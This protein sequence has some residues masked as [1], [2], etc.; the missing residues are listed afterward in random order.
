[1]DYSKFEKMLE[2]FKNLNISH[3]SR[4]KTFMDVSGYP[5]YEN[6]VSNILAF[7]FDDSEEHGF[8]N[9]WLNSLLSCAKRTDLEDAHAAVERE[10]F[11][12]KNNRI[13]LLITSDRYILCIENKIFA[14]VYNDLKD[15]AKDIP[16]K[17]ISK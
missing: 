16:H 2:G 17:N 6:V 4:R 14:D 9:L 8:G 5:H 11:T 12:S 1:M 15:Y 13:D 7:F 10:V 3:P